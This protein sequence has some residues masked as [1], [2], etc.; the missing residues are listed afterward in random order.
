MHNGD[1]NK[2]LPPCTCV[3]AAPWPRENCLNT[4]AAV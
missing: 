1:I 4:I 3:Q 2:Y